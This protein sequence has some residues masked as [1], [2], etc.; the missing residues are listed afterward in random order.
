MLLLYSRPLK[1]LIL[2]PLSVL[3]QRAVKETS[4]AASL[5]DWLMW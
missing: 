5:L 2:L 4:E 3:E 1:N